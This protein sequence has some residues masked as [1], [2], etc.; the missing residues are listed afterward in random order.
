MKRAHVAPADRAAM[1]RT[2]A[3]LRHRVIGAHRGPTRTAIE[4]VNGAAGAIFAERDLDVATLVE[5]ILRH[6]V[7]NFGLGCDCPRSA[8]DAAAKAWAGD[9]D[10]ERRAA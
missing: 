6:R 8:A 5:G 1:A 4:I 7:R 10:E 9:E 2:V 3:A